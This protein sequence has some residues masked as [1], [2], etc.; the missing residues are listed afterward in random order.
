MARRRL[1]VS[2]VQSEF[3]RERKALRDFLDGDPLMRRF[4]EVFLFEDTPASD[5]RP[6]ELYLDEAQ[7]CD[8][9]VGLFGNDYG[10]E[11]E[12][13]CS[14]TEREFD[15]ATEVSA[16][17]LIFVK[18]RD[19]GNRHPKM[20]ALIGKAQAGL[21]RKRFNTI[22]ELVDELRE[23]LVEYMEAVE[24]LRL[25]P[26]DAA[27]CIDSALTDLD[28]ER[29]ARF[30][31]TAR[32]ARDLALPEGA[33]PSQL[34]EHLKLLNN[35][36]PTN[37]AVLLFGKT[38]QRFLMSS[39]I[40]CA[41]F[42]GTEVYK[43][44]PS[45]QVYKGTAFELVDQAL[46]F[47]L[48]KLAL[49]VGTRAKS[50]QAP[51]SYE[52]PM[53]V[54]KEAIVNAVAHRDYTSNGSVQVMLFTDRLEVRNPGRLPPQL[55]L[56]KL[57]GPHA[58]IPGNPLLAE[59]LYLAKYIERM[60]TGTLDMIRR[61]IAASLPEPEFADTGE[62]VTTVW[63]ACVVRAVCD[64]TPVAGVAVQV[65]SPEGPVER[66]TTDKQGEARIGS[67]ARAMPLT[68][69][70]S[71]EGFAACVE[72]DWTPAERPL[73]LDLQRFAQGGSVILRDGAGRL[74]GLNGIL[75]PAKDAADRI[76]LYASNIA[77]NDGQSQPVRIALG[78]EFH[79]ADADGNEL[80][81]RVVDVAGRSALVEYRVAAG[82][83]KR[84]QE[85][86]LEWLEAIILGLLA[87]K[88]MSKAEFMEQLDSNAVSRNLQQALRLLLAGGLIEQTVPDRPRSRL[89]RYRLASKGRMALQ[90]LGRTRSRS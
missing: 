10:Y 35:G 85:L 42:H 9:Y 5:R 78:E 40:K 79:L 16:H 41:H 60:G 53:E 14:P 86:Q 82:R 72:R 54:V 68:V 30:V 2:S 48:G 87:S 57:R 19:D 15:R 12:Q 55:T 27:T 69:L 29:M 8:L 38:P 76:S 25:G 73:S 81:A 7:R 90:N 20:R 70:A 26:F 77:I 66:S 62:F 39:E 58:S 50:V 22:E 64:G 33:N 71:A 47:V 13:G 18:G 75:N 74:P 4:F 59:S 51:V 23:A 46:D 84:R 32:R 83:A 52:I 89:P 31:R 37:A 80:L 3:A 49:S 24:L 56:E 44:I 43:P 34:L 1:F 67:S 88:P 36:R 63:R 6:D 45:Y 21:I 28:S 11:D 61:C 65:H 17:R